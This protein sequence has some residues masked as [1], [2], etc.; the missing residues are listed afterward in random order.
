M[1]IDDYLEKLTIEPVKH[2]K[3]YKIHP[4][5]GN[6]NDYIILPET[7]DRPDI[8]V[9]RSTIHY[10]GLISS[11]ILDKHLENTN[12]FLL[13]LSYFV[14]LLDY[15]FCSSKFY[16]AEGI[17]IPSYENVLG[18]FIKQIYDDYEFLGN[19]F[20]LQGGFNM[21][22]ENT[23]TKIIDGKL[24]KVSE[25]LDL[26]ALFEDRSISITPW[27]KD[28]TPQGFPRKNCLY[29]LNDYEK[30]E[31][32]SNYVIDFS[33]DKFGIKNRN[34]IIDLDIVFRPALIL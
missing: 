2:K 33:G 25:E 17:Q 6:P 12:I 23:Y 20:S 34:M 28:P 5:I 13:P 30:P 1:P 9:K 29:G 31:S 21:W 15:L 27:I 19:T 16:N 18:N 32:G 10:P 24:K 22:W 14:E 7:K 26:D 11:Q 3:T 4:F 8:L